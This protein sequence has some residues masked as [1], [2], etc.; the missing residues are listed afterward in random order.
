MSKG[1]IEVIAGGMFSGKSEELVRRLRRATIARKKVFAIKHSSD[2]RYHQTHIGCH[3]GVTFEATP[4]RTTVGISQFLD[5][6]SVPAEV[7]GIDEGQFFEWGLLDLCE[8]LA[9]RGIRVIV[10]GLD[11]DS[12]GKP[13]GPI[14]SLMAVAEEVTK[15][16]AVCM[17]CGE[18]ASRSYHKAGKTEQVEVGAS[19]YEAR[20]RKCWS[21]GVDVHAKG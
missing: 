21:L 20:C 1:R 17:V 12:N 16:H 18:E 11:Q 15:L 19:Q 3:T 10:A 7:V 6:V 5:S 14:P 13:F 4:L 2:D 9:N 8:E